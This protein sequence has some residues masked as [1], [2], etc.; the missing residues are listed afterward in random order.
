MD[1]KHLFLVDGAAGTGK[2]DLIE[3]VKS[4]LHDRRT[5][6]VRK[7]TTRKR[8][9]KE[10]AKQHLLDL[11]FIS[12]EEFDEKAKDPNFYSYHYPQHDRARYGFHRDEIESMLETCEAVFLIVRNTGTIRDLK[13][14]FQDYQVSPL[15]VYTHPADVR[16]R[17]QEEGESEEEIERRISRSADAM[18]DLYTYPTLYERVF[19]NDAG[20][21]TF[22]RQLLDYYAAVREPDPTILR[23]SAR[24]HY[25]L[26]AQLRLH[27][28][29]MLKALKRR[30]YE[31]NVFVMM[32]FQ[33]ESDGTFRLI[34]KEVDA[35]GFH[36]VRA[37]MSEW[38]LT[39]DVYNPYAIMH[40]CKYGIGLFDL[41][42]TQPEEEEPRYHPNVAIELAMMHLQNK[43]CLMLKHHRLPA[44]APFDL[45]SQIYD[46]YYRTED[47]LAQVEHWIKTLQTTPN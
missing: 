27:K 14:D 34:K 28:P 19:I 12:D 40:C 47:L 37:D 45:A 13:R 18:H 21:D 33:P 36:C 38:N 32:R 30:P 44:P 15:F 10:K 29:A 16:L 23:I 1:P 35:A 9:P 6:V 46:Q 2:T 26:P 17:L 41:D 43:Q 39:K 25:Q 42:E 11:D 4:Q 7:Y 20:R 31:K 8:R 3:F 5:S 24:E 22:R